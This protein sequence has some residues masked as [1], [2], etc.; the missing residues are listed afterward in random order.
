MPATLTTHT[1]PPSAP[2][3]RRVTI[4]ASLMAALD[5]AWT[6]I[7]ARHPEVPDVAITTGTAGDRGAARAAFTGATW[8][9]GDGDQVPELLIDGQALTS[10]PAA[11]GALLHHAAH[12][13]AH[14]RGI[15][16]TSR[17]GRYHSK[18]YADLAR[19][20]GLQVDQNTTA[21]WADT[22]V[23]TATA[24]QYTEVLGDLSTALASAVRVAEPRSTTTGRTSSNNPVSATCACPRRIRAAASVLQLGP[25]ICGICHQPF[26]S[27]GAE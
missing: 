12:G 22:R 16:D 23:P 14:A 6:A 7:R 18:A 17:Q 1:A 10:G 11:L 26:Q 8:D 4:T 9:R 24:D 2:T 5:Q 27:A 3:I 25:I 20:L 13:L 21:G 15:K 19:E